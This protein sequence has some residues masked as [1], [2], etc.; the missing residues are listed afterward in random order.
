MSDVLLLA[1]FTWLPLDTWTVTIAALAAMACAL[2][3][4]FLVLR[5]MSMMG[6]AISHAVLPGLAAAFLLS[7]SRSSIAM[8]IG[9][10]IVG[11]LTAVFTEW[12]RRAGRVDEGASMGVVFTILFALGLILIRQAADHVDLDPDCVLHGSLDLSVLDTRSILGVEIPRAALVTGGMFLAN[13]LLVVLLY[14]ELKISSFDPELATTVGINARLLHYLLMTVIAI[15]T[16]CAFEAVGSILVIAMLIVPPAAAHLLTDRLSVMLVLGVLLA[17]L[18]AALGHIGAIAVPPCLGYA[19]VSTST[20]GM[21]AVAAGLIFVLALLVSPRHGVISRWAH[22]AALSLRIAREDVLAL[23]YRIEERSGQ[24]APAVLR[25]SLSSGPLLTAFALRSLRR[26]GW[27]ENPAGVLQLTPAGRDQAR[28]LIRSH[29]LWETYFEE[30]TTL[31]VDHVHAPAEKLEHVTSA[32]LQADLAAEL[33]RRAIDP[34][35][36]PIPPLG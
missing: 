5:K 36:R 7:G 26:R 33:Q 14:K 12:I 24:A 1:E 9:A 13:T 17:A 3:G 6:D 18:S 10:A 34:Q 29:R 11:V 20:A 27:I 2:P 19:G 28:G 4:T 32:A 35:G 21:V 23:L 8:L 16:V 31:P 25:D 30:H 15:T 22:R